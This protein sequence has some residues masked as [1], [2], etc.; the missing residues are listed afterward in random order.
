MNIKEEINN[1][2]DEL[3]QLR[4]DFHK[5]PELGF[6][7]FRTSKIVADY[8]EE[9]GL[10]VTRGIAKTGVMGLLEGK[11]PGPTLLLR[12]DMDALPIQEANKVSYKSVNSGIMHA[13]GHDAH[14]AILLITAKILSSYWEEISGNIK[15][16]FQPNE[17][18]GGAD[19]MIKEGILESPRVDAA[20]ALHLWTPLESGII[21][22]KTGP[23]TGALDV[24]HLT[25]K[26][27]GGHTGYPEKAVDPIIV[28]ANVIQSIQAIQTREISVFR[29]TIIMFTKINGGTKSNII[30]DS[31]S[32]E[33]SI[34]YFNK[35]EDKNEESL[36]EKFERIVEA[37]CKAYR[38][39]YEL[40]FFNENKSVVNDKKM[41]ELVIFSAKEI[42][43]QRDKVLSYQSIAGE[44]FSEFADRVPSAFYFV[45][46]GNR[47]KE[48]HYPHHNPNFNID[49]D[50]MLTGVEMHIFCALNWNKGNFSR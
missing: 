1:L 40:K 5:H 48:S 49:E 30:P 3:I 25:I 2:K 29:P 47:E 19:L 13:C 23:I 45:G 44:D 12:A 32:L 9:C 33:G 22:V 14:T 21:G 37:T 24:F 41:T 34:R 42:L 20:I 17:E 46:T 7:E 35:Q 31:V 8:L 6:K 26:G 50:T 38:V 11:N 43:G 27:E 4:R 10:K 18:I 15:F 39:K 16:I 36:N 28:S